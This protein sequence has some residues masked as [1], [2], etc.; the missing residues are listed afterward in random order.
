MFVFSAIVTHENLTTEELVM[1]TNMQENVIRFAVKS[2]LDADIIVRGSDGRYR[3]TTLWYH[4][5][6]SSL[7]R[8]NMLHE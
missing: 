2:A 4:T 1:V 3:I 6:V 7:N 8:K 5:V